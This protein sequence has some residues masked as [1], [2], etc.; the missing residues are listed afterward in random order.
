MLKGFFVSK[1]KYLMGAYSKLH[2]HA[3]EEIRR[4]FPHF[5]IRENIRPEWLRSSNLTKLE[6]DIYIEDIETAIEIQGQQHYVY[7]PYFHKSYDDFREQMRRDREKRDLC[8][9]KGIKL[10]EIAE[11]LDVKIFVDDL[12][13]IERQK[14]AEKPKFYYSNPTPTTEKKSKPKPIKLETENKKAKYSLAHKKAINKARKEQRKRKREWMIRKGIIPKKEVIILPG[15]QRQR[16]HARKIHCSKISSSL[17]FVWGGE[18]GIHKVSR[19]DEYS[20]DCLY[21]T[22]DKML[23]S[24]IIRVQMYRREFPSVAGTPLNMFHLP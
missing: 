16:N 13:E 3:Y 21:N 17:W 12:K 6:L 8:Y 14:Q 11:T 2:D 20:C 5:T 7:T 23:C 22:R 15:K 1:F 4:N 9:G 18:K 10:V 24:H 19:H